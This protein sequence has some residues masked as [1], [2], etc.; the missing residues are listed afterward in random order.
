MGELKYY[1]MIYI[2]GMFEKLT[3]QIHERDSYGVY[4]WSG[5]NGWIVSAPSNNRAEA[6]D[7]SNELMG[8]LYK[9]MVIK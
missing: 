3:I 8:K 7:V 4:S 1:G 9:G 2:E 5:E 6:V